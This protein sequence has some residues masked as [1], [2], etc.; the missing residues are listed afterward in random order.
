MKKKTRLGGASGEVWV[1]IAVMLIAAAGLFTS[2]RAWAGTTNEPAAPTNSDSAM[3]TLADI[4]NVLDTRTTN[5]AKRTVVF[6]EPT[7]GPTNGT[8]Y[9]LNEIM[10]LVTNRAPVQKTGQTISYLTGDNGTYQIGVAWPNPRF[11]Q[12]GV[13]GQPETNQIRDNLTGLIWARNANIPGGAMPWTNA[14]QY[15]S[16]NLNVNVPLY[17]GTNDWRLPNWQ[18][19]RSLI[20]ASK[21]SPALPSG[22]PFAGVQLNPYRYWSSA[23]AAGNTAGAWTVR[24]GDG[25]VSNGAKV[26]AYYVWPVR[27]GQ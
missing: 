13:S 18:E 8:M 21:S 7:G 19:L 23:T 26:T 1:L 12:L 2:G 20:D 16:T 22:H 15:C 17:G 9:T 14:V 10:T 27:G 11:T 4:Y 5:V 3:W 25:Y 6:T 24:L